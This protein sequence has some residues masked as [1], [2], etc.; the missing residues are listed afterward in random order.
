M[1]Q[2]FLIPIWLHTQKDMP[3]RVHHHTAITKYRPTYHMVIK[4]G[5]QEMLNDVSFCLGNADSPL[6]TRGFC[7]WTISK[8]TFSQIPVFHIS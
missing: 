5:N 6:M 4:P 7:K 8:E 3:F 2:F 1:T